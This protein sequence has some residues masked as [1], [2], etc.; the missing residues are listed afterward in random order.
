MK[1]DFPRRPAAGARPSAGGRLAAGGWLAVG[2]LAL[3]M[4]AAMPVQAAEHAHDGPAVAEA[5]AHSH[6]HAGEAPALKLDHGRKWASDEALRTSMSRIG[7]AVDASLAAVHAGR[8]SEAQYDALGREIEAQVANIV[9]NCRLEPAADEVLHAILATMMEG[10]ETLQGKN[11][12]AG[13]SAGVV[14]VVEALGQYGDH[15]EHA[16]FVAPKTGH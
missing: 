13:R 15:F 2:S 16:G 10:N 9:Q 11:P 8:M 6:G 4:Q 14:Q 1:H 12:K 5:G 3:A 7:T